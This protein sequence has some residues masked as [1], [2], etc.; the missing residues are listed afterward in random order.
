MGPRVCVFG[1]DHM[2]IVGMGCS[3]TVCLLSIKKREKFQVHIFQM[4]YSFLNSIL[5][6]YRLQR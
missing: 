6:K 2:D 1:G 4:A 3:A 5:V